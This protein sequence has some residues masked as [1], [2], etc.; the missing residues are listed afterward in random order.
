M[1]RIREIPELGFE[2]A[3]WGVGNTGGCEDIAVWGVGNT[4]G[5]EDITDCALCL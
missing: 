3:D 2:L 4:G 5:F 1:D